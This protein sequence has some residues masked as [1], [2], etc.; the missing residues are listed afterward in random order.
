MNALIRGGLSAMRDVAFLVR[1]PEGTTGI[2]RS[3]HL[4]EGLLPEDEIR[5]QEK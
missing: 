2:Q 1:L 3:R 5:S 4:L